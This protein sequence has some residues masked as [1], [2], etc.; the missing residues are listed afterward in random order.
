MKKTQNMNLKEINSDLPL[1]G[2]PSQLSDGPR[3]EDR[4]GTDGEGLGGS[5]RA[6]APRDE[7]TGVTRVGVT[8]AGV[9][10]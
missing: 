3:K 4:G 7:L 10:T 6:G 9:G 5:E 8:G 1:G 2:G